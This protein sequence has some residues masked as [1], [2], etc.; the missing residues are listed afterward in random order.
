[1]LPEDDSDRKDALDP[2]RV[3]ATIDDH[4]RRDDSYLDE[5]G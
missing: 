3:A 1:V 5:N 4:T 2:Y